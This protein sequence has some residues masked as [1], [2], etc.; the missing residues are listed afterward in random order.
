MTDV[1]PKARLHLSDPLAAGDS[2]S[3]SGDPAHYLRTVMRAVPGDAVGV[4]NGRDGEWLA[5]ITAVDRRSCRL[6]VETNVRPQRTETGPWLLFAPIKKTA[7]DFLV[8]KATEL[9]AERLWPV[10]TER[11]VTQR[12]NLRRLRAHAVEAAEQCERLIVPHV[13]E[14]VA[15]SRLERS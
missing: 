5:R 3:V 12:V 13:A 15:L 9:G 14:P 2:I 10:I 1:K 4:F 8:E 6:A 11:T 7:L